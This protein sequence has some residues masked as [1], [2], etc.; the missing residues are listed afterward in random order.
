MTV[1][2]TWFQKKDIYYG[3]G[4]HPATK[5]FHM[6][7]YVV[8][9]AKQTACCIVVQV[10]RGANCWTDHKKL[11]RAKLMVDLSR[12]HRAEKMM[13]PFFFSFFFCGCPQTFNNK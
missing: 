6:I 3:T 11:V 8:M 13:M 12:A 2:N 10:M 7:D 9:R 1:M 4:M 5:E